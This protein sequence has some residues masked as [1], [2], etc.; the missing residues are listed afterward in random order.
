M[1]LTEMQLINRSI[2][3]HG[4]TKPAPEDMTK[5]KYHR[6]PNQQPDPLNLSTF[7][8]FR[9]CYLKTVNK[10]FHIVVGWK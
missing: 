1:K 5:K 9:R 2:A 7:L 6:L 4:V 8:R 10:L 3:N